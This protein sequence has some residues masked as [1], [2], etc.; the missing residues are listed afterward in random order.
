MAET[1]QAQAG[2]APAAPTPPASKPGETA[3]PHEALS[4]QQKFVELRKAVPLII[5][6]KHSDGVSYKFSKIFDVWGKITPIMNEIGVNFDIV[7][8]VAT[9][10][11][12]HGD[13]AY[14]STMTTKTRNGDKLMF[15]YEADL[16][17]CWIN[18]DNED[19][20]S[21]VTLHAIGWNDDPAKAKGAA[22]TYALKYYLFEKF[23]I[24]QGEDAPDNNDFSGAPGLGRPLGG[25]KGGGQ[26]NGQQQGNGALEGRG[27]P[28]PLTDRQLDRLYRKG[29][30]AGH[31]KEVIN[32]R[33]LDK[34]HKENPA[35]LTRAEYDEICAAL[36]KA[37]AEKG[38]SANV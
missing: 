12:D 31:S 7:S 10:K 3:I 4:L 38:G 20:T 27:C 26:H 8:E 37:A 28:R 35:D 16:T 11:D 23:T 13:P 15:L 30:A 25:Q 33:I 9:R 29:E 21:T 1:K 22:W 24:D 36:D 32:K 6:E 18:T 17:V 5:K 34:Y 2:A 14:Y 19:D